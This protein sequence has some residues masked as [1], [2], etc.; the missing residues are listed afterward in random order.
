MAARGPS[1]DRQEALAVGRERVSI[2]FGGVSSEHDVSLKGFE[3]VYEYVRSSGQSKLELDRVLYVD[4]EGRVVASPAELDKPAE[5]YYQRPSVERETL[6]ACFSGL[7]G[8][9][10]FFF[11]VLHGQYGEDGRVAS[12]A[13]QSR[14]HGSFGSYLACGLAMSKDHMNAY[15]RGLGLDVRIPRTRCLEPGCDVGRIFE[16]LNGATVVVKPNSLGS[17]VLAE[18]LTADASAKPAFVDLVEQI[19]QFDRRAL[20]QDFV[21]GVEYSCGCLRRPQ[22]VLVMP[23]IRVLPDR[24]QFF[25]HKQKHDASSGRDE[26]L[27]GPTEPSAAKIQQVSRA[28]FEATGFEQMCRFDYIV[29]A[30]GE[31]YFLEANPLPGLMQRSFYSRML[32]EAGLDMGDLILQ[33]IENERAKR[34]LRT[35]IR[36][37]IG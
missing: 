4:T 19:L 30:E 36:Y 14:V 24:G 3:N 29:D 37:M 22:D 35:T 11:S 23:V 21:E 25:G 31:V 20:V 12:L 33:T 27:L 26:E 18:K 8:S 6:A 32:N 5:Y 7:S 15:V 1:R 9:D 16:E 10:E 17:S 28:L 2:I 34:T 13:E